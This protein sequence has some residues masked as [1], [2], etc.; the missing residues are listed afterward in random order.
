MLPPSPHAGAHVRPVGSTVIAPTPT[1]T[2][3]V[4]PA[5]GE[6]GGPSTVAPVE[7]VIVSSL[8][9]PGATQTFTTTS[10]DA[11][12]GIA[13]ARA[14]LDVEIRYEAAASAGDRSEIR[15]RSIVGRAAGPL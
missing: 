5:T 6:S 10:S 4:G 8:G 7:L 3:R 11:P 12:A 1:P 2:T 15:T 13:P 9:A 14:S